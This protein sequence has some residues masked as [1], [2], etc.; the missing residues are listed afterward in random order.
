M[1][2]QAPWQLI[3]FPT[4]P[5]WCPMSA[6]QLITALTSVGVVG[7]S[8]QGGS[9]NR[10]LIGPRFLQYI[11]FMGC[12]PA[13]QFDPNEGN[14][15]IHWIVNPCLHEPAWVIDKVQA[16]PR[17]HWCKARI[18]DWREQLQNFAVATTPDAMI[19]PHC[20]QSNQLTQLD[21]RHGAGYAR[22]FI[23]IVNIYP[24]EAIPTD[25][26]L[27]AMQQHTG[28][29]WQYCYCQADPEG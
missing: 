23:R 6:D 11:S 29:A 8:W 21:W 18:A 24:R 17:C 2:D 28:V 15:I 9:N 10:F 5:Q 16:L 13:V 7:E 27:T 3:F 4:D 26:V 19:C 14:T 22:Q 1:T 20:H 25:A 12:A